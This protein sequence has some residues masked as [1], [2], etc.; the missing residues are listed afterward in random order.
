MEAVAT[1]MALSVMSMA[2][3]NLVLRL[4]RG[5]VI[6]RGLHLGSLNPIHMG[7]TSCIPL[8]NLSSTDHLNHALGDDLL[9]D[10]DRFGAGEEYLAATTS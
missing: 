3:G 8:A 4:S 7:R 9:C 5:H 10:G 6:E 2:M 1:I